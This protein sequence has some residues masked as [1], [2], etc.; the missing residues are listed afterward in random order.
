MEGVEFTSSQLSGSNNSSS[1]NQAIVQQPEN[2]GQGLCS[3]VHAL[4][5]KENELTVSTALDK[6]DKQPQQSWT[7]I[8]KAKQF[9]LFFW[10][11][12]TEK[13]NYVYRIIWVAVTFADS[14][15]EQCFKKEWVIRFCKHIFPSTLSGEERNHRFKYVLKLANLPSGLETAQKTINTNKRNV[16]IVFTNQFIKYE[17]PTNYWEDGLDN[18]KDKQNSILIKVQTTTEAKIEQFINLLNK[19]N[20]RLANI[21]VQIL[22]SKVPSDT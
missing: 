19:A 1:S 7:V 21:E 22:N 14:K 5:H 8:G 9:Q 13:K 4:S 16:R 20:N 15:L 10:E 11:N 17:D 3:S 18:W 6:S 12:P 2:N